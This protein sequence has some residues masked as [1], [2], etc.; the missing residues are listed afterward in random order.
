MDIEARLKVVEVENDMLRERINMLER[1]LGAQYVAPLVLCL[2]A[3]EA[4]V[5]GHMLERDHV[6][7]DSVMAV[8]YR[9]LARDEAEPKIVDV[10]ICKIRKKFKP[11]GI[12]IHTLWGQG[13]AL[14][15]A[16][17]MALRALAADT[18][19]AAMPMA[20]SA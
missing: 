1:A 15:P 20:V 13:Y 16:S 4:R 10:Y 5:V 9:D 8:L 11:F 17:K 3:T 14:P 19:R 18:F 6:T 7:K 2:T 12:S